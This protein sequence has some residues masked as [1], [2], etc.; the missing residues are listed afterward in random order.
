MLS[1]L[2]LEITRDDRLCYWKMVRRFPLQVLNFGVNNLRYSVAENIH[3]TPNSR[4]ISAAKLKEELPFR[5][6]W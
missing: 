5:G 4:E 2:D 1:L 6:Q 3:R